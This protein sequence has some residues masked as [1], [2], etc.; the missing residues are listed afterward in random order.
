MAFAF[1]SSDFESGREYW[2]DMVSN[3]HVAVTPEFR[4]TENFHAAMKIENWGGLQIS[5]TTCST[6]SYL[7]GLREMRRSVH[8]DFLCVLALDS[9]G[10]L[11]TSGRLLDFRPGDL[12]V[13]DTD[14]LYSLHYTGDART[15]SLRVPRPLMISRLHQADRH[16]AVRLDGSRPLARLAGN[17]LE[18]VAGLEGPDDADRRRE[19]EAPILDILRL[20]VTE[21]CDTDMR[22]TPGQAN[23][24]DRVKKDLMQRIGDSELDV[25]TIAQ[26]HGVSA[27]T[28]NRLFAAEGTTVMRWIWSQRLAAAY[29]AMSDGSI[30]QVTEAAFC[31][32][33]KDTSHFSRAFKREFNIPPSMLLAR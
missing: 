4:D 14:Q 33:F 12:L 19:A 9:G 32:G 5:E 29:R 8:N 28:L 24:L 10:T 11:E 17:L 25:D 7:H 31:Y 6:I 3:H 13:Y 22:P 27:R 16:F 2:R 30:R 15:I 20:A 23:M 1:Q 18:N 21:H 26:L